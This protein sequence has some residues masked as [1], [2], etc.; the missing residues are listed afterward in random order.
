MCHRVAFNTVKSLIKLEVC[1]HCAC[2][3]F[4]YCVQNALAHFRG[5]MESERRHIMC[6]M[7]A[8]SVYYAVPK[9]N[10]DLQPG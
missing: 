5:K 7:A 6:Q 4:R 8:E 2:E 1:L 10:F 9:R 3:S